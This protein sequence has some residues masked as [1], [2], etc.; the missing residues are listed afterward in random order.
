MMSAWSWPGGAWKKK[1]VEKRTLVAHP[2]QPLERPLDHERSADLEQARGGGAL[3]EDVEESR[4]VEAALGSEHERLGDGSRVEAHEEIR[5]EL[6][7]TGVADRADMHEALG[8]RLEHRTAALGER[9]VAADEDRAV[10]L[11]HHRRRAAHRRVEEADAAG[12]GRLA[13]R[14]RERRRDGAHLEHHRVA[15]HRVQHTLRTAH[16]PVDGF[17]RRE[18]HEYG[19]DVADGRRDVRGGRQ[20]LARQCL[21][22]F[23]AYVVARDGEAGLEQSPG[24]SAPQEPQPYDPYMSHASLLFIDSAVTAR[25]D[26]AWSPRRPPAAPACTSARSGR[27]TGCGCSRRARGPTACSARRGESTAPAA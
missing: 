22:D 27:A 7:E 16:D 9:G 21:D 6:G 12:G 23:R 26:G 25:G 10:A 11:G 2:R 14:T 17:Q 24:H 20:P 13:E 4:G 1:K 15:T 5:G 3:P 8:D 18:D 19:V